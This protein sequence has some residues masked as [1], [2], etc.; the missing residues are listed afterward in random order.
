MRKS[1]FRKSKNALKML[2]NEPVI[3]KNGVDVAKN[4][5]C[6]VW[7]TGIAVYLVYWHTGIPGKKVPPIPVYP[8]Q[9]L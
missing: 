3:A 8:K 9:S 6:K 5:P 2:Q 1:Y 7:V 4:G